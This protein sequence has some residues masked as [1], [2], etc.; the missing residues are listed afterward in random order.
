M[1]I[2]IKH[3]IE[4]EY[5][6]PPRSVMQ[7]L[8]LSPRD[9]EGQHVASWRIDIDVDGRLRAG[10]DAYRNHVHSL[11]IDGPVDRFAIEVEG[12]V[13]TTDLNGMVRGTLERFPLPV[14][15]RESP[16]AAPDEAILKLASTAIIGIGD[17]LDRAHRLAGAVAEAVTFDPEPGHETVTAADALEMGKASAR[18][19]AH[20]LVAAARC[21]GVPARYV[22]GYRLGD[23]EG[24][25]SAA[26]HAWAEL[27]VDGYGWVAF[28]P[29]HRICPTDSYVRTATGLDAQGAGPLRTSRIGGAGE[30]RREIIRVMQA[31]RRIRT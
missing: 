11:A 9:H 26:M 27:A 1:R 3:R 7:V 6:V 14:W 17:P 10:E 12:E 25:T 23:D 2:R 29:S 28:D 24:A 22:S 4:Q 30:T 15:L 5:E 20:L 8:R 13:D 18:D 16:L 31:G 21:S 19:L